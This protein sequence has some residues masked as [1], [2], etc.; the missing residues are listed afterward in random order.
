ML[1]RKTAYTH[2][3]MSP[4][5]IAS[6]KGTQLAGIQPALLHQWHPPATTLIPPE[7]KRA[8][9]GLSHWA[10]GSILSEQ[11]QHMTAAI[12]VH[13]LSQSPPTVYRPLVSALNTDLPAIAVMG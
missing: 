3:H 5:S 12:H 4:G 13:S 10:A 11:A 1:A 6:S 8:V 9:T 2:V 7:D